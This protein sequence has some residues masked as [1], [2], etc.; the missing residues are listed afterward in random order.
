MSPIYDPRFSKVRR[1]RDLA[2]ERDAADQAARMEPVKPLVLLAVAG[3]TVVIA[4]AVRGSPGAGPPP[5]LLYPVQLSLGVAAGT[6]GLW[7]ASKLWLGGAG[8][9]GLAILRLAAVHAAVDVIAV[10]T[11]PMFVGPVFYGPRIVWFWIV[12]GICFAWLLCWLFDLDISDSILLAII[13][14][15]LKIATA[16]ALGLL[17]AGP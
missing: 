11:L 1:N 9:L 8:P 16:L 5:A 10:I 6:L 2:A 15:V 14:W 12:Q 17:L 7:A 3:T 4:L 13:T